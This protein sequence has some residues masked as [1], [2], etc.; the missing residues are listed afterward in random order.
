MGG[1]G[2]GQGSRVGAGLALGLGLGGAVWVVG[3]DGHGALGWCF[4][5]EQHREEAEL[6]W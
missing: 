5:R 1:S 3:F 6:A 2:K 4:T